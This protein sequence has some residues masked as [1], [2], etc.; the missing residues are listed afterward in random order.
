MIARSAFGTFTGNLRGWRTGRSRRQS[1]TQTLARLRALVLALTCLTAVASS[2][3]VAIHNGFLTGLKYLDLSQ[4][5]QRSYAAGF[6]DGIFLAPLFDAPKTG[7]L[8]D[9]EA[10]GTG[11]NDEQVAAILTTHLRSRPELWHLGTHTAMY[12]A[13][14]ERCPK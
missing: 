13:L 11:M 6:I 12:S 4:A 9:I 8:A 5:H 1:R 7:R 14:R 2:Q 3:P 10:C